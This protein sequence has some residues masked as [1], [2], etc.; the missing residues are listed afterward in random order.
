MFSAGPHILLINQWFKVGKKVN[1]K[2]PNGIK[3]KS[4]QEELSVSFLSYEQIKLVKI[5]KFE[6][7]YAMQNCET[8]KIWIK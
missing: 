5:S 7:T 2:D 4:I 8:S 1:N 3:Q 6:S